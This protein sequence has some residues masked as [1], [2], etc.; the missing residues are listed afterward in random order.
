VL[1][2]IKN[3]DSTA[4]TWVGQTIE[5]GEYYTVQSTQLISWQNDDTLLAAIA[6]GTA[7]V[8]NGTSDISGVNNQINFLKGNGPVGS[9]GAPIFESGHITGVPGSKSVSIVTPNLGDR[10]TWYQKSFKVTTETLTD[11]GDGLTFTSANPWW[12][13]IRDKKLTYTHKQVPKRDGT[14]GK[15]ADWDVA[16]YVDA[17]LASTS[18]YTVNYTAGTVTFNSSKAGSTITATYWTNNGVTN[19]SEWLFQPG[20]GKKFIIT[21]V[22][23]QYSM[24]M[25]SSFD[26]IRF[27]VWGGGNLGIYSGNAAVASTV[28]SGGGIYV[29]GSSTQLTTVSS[30]FTQPSA[31]GTVNVTVGSTTGM[32]AS[33]ALYVVGGGIYVV[34]AVVS[35]TV[36]VLV[37]AGYASFSDS[38]YNLG[39]GQFRADYRN[40]WDI[41]NTSNNQ[42]STRI[43]AHSE[44]TQDIFV[45]PYNYTQATV[46]DSAVGAMLRV[47]M[48]NDIPIPTVEIATG[49]FYLTIY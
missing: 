12:V 30:S 29:L 14:F 18:T 21:C 48:A 35:S 31:G 22:E 11:S 3:N 37:N 2:K 16:V 27:E 10:T 49:T 24:N 39:F 23:L 34:G 20:S 38:I 17:V 1:V 44:M 5:A 41:I 36:V 9:S 13:N 19:P 15:H 26:T 8:N 4:H 33:Q 46:L 7:I 47:C 25:P 45:A 40:V 32:S 28:S 42:A 6:A 43:P